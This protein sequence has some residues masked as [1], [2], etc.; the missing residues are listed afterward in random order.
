MNFARAL[1]SRSL[2]LKLNTEVVSPDHSDATIN[3]HAITSRKAFWALKPL[4]TKVE[5]I[6]HAIRVNLSRNV[7]FSRKPKRRRKNFIFIGFRV[8]HCNNFSSTVAS[9]YL[10]RVA[11]HMWDVRS[12]TQKI[13]KNNKLRDVLKRLWLAEKSRHDWTAFPPP[14]VICSIVI[15]TRSA[16]PLRTVNVEIITEINASNEREKSRKVSWMVRMSARTFERLQ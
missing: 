2:D 13:I 6:R 4:E 15:A 10:V 12:E 8:F 11:R 14:I 5:L 3:R 16:R 9:E 7:N 1:K